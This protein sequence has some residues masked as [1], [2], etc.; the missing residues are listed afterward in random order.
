MSAFEQAPPRVDRRSNF[1]GRTPALDPRSSGRGPRY[2]PH[3][4]VIPRRRVSRRPRQ[5]AD[6]RPRPTPL[7]V[8]LL[9]DVV[10]VVLH[11]R[12]L[13][14][15]LHAH[16]LVREP[17]VD[18]VD[19]LQLARGQARLWRDVSLH[20]G[21]CGDTAR[22][23]PRPSAASSAPRLASQHACFRRGRLLLRSRAQTPSRP[24]RR[25]RSPRLR[26]Q[27]PQRQQPSPVRVS[28]EAAGSPRGSPATAHRRQR[29]P[30]RPRR[31]ASS[32]SGA[33]QP[34]TRISS[35][36]SRSARNPFDVEAHRA[37]EE[38]A[39]HVRDQAQVSAPRS[40][41]PQPQRR[42]PK[43]ASNTGR[44]RFPQCLLHRRA[45]EVNLRVDPRIQILRA[46]LVERWI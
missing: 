21:Q 19:D 33:A 20:S 35:R 9:E 12:D 42:L 4:R 13:D 7:D 17:L 38:D 28:K 25:L 46:H 2:G 41:E 14:P 45:V 40:R 29:R 27:G 10:H 16:L 43:P 24:P 18:E 32:S 34:T 26:R 11:R 6:A 1:S 23:A 44:P 15:E 8:E 3:A 37:D 5:R 39:N 36:P 30:A 22:G 31:V